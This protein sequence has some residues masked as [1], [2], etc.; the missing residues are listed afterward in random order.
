VHAVNLVAGSV[1]ELLV[2]VGEQGVVDLLR[3]AAGAANQVVMSGL[4]EFIDKLPAPDMGR[5]DQSLLA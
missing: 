1:L 3:L 5:Q 2:K 4:G